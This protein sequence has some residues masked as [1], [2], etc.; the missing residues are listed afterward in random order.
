MEYRVFENHL[1]VRIDKD[2]EILNTV[3]NLAQKENIK[4]ATLSAIGA[5]S[6]VELGLFKTKQ[7]EYVSNRY[8]GDFEIISLQGTISQMDQ[9]TYI[10]AHLSIADIDQKCIGGHCNLAVVSATCE[11]VIN[12]IEGEI[13]RKFSNKIGLN[14]MKF[15]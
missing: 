11:L 2:E 1:V 5:V 7:K 14:L 15:L 10:H 3:K 9:E 13:D 12:I 6:D 8:Q 4:L